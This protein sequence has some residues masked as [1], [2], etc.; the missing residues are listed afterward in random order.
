MAEPQPGDACDLILAACNAA[1]Y[2][3]GVGSSG[4]GLWFNC[5]EPVMQGTP[6]QSAL[7]RPT[8][9]MLRP[10]SMAPTATR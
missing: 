6:A 5:V 2:V 3:E 4:K 8:I 9:A 1:G 7:P 10:C